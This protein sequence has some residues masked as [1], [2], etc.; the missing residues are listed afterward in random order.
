MFQFTYSPTTFVICYIGFKNHADKAAIIM[1]LTTINIFLKSLFN[2]A[3]DQIKQIYKYMWYLLEFILCVWSN[4]PLPFYS[5]IVCIISIVVITNLFYLYCCELHWY[6]YWKETLKRTTW[7]NSI[8]N[9][10]IE[11]QVASCTY[12]F[13]MV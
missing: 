7:I 4:K 3:T 5:L 11:L 6:L 12:Y 9:I 1:S 10:I 13:S 8:Y 2:V